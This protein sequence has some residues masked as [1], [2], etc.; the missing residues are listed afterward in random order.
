MAQ[1]YAHL[2]FFIHS[3]YATRQLLAHK[4]MKTTRSC[5]K[6]V[7]NYHGDILELKVAQVGFV[8]RSLL[9]YKPHP[10]LALPF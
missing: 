6:T 8:Q 3:T 2:V 7:F 9:S 5:V 10:L 4:E 1:N